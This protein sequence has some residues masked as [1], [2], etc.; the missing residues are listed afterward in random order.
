[1]MAAPEASQEAS[2]GGFCYCLLLLQLFP[3]GQSRW[4]LLA[5]WQQLQQEPVWLESV[6]QRV[7][8]AQQVLSRSLLWKVQQLLLS[9][10][11]SLYPLWLLD[12]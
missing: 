1:M 2:G 9:Q 12:S 7:Q 3:S 5:E 6:L 4:E 10:L 8:A 11:H